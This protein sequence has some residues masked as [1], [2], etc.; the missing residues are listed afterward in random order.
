[1]TITEQTIY[2]AILILT[3]IAIGL[4]AVT[5]W[6]VRDTRPTVMTGVA[7]LICASLWILTEALQLLSPDARTALLWIKIEQV[8]IAPIPV[9]WV[10]LSMQVTGNESSLSTSRMIALSTIPFLSMVIL[11]LNESLG[12][13]MSVTSADSAMGSLVLQPGPAMVLFYIY[14]YSVIIGST[15]LLIQRMRFSPS[16]RWQGM[17]V[18]V[19]VCLCVIASIID[20]V[21]L[22]TVSMVKLTPL[23]LAISIP[24]YILT[25]ARTRR[26]DLVP[27]A[28]NNVL[29]II[30]DAVIVLDTEKRIIDMNPAAETLLGQ[31]LPKV[32]GKEINEAWQAWARQI[33]TLS[34]RPRGI[35][36]VRLSDGDQERV[37]D[38]RRSELKDWHGQLVSRVIVLRDITE[39]ALAE[40]ALQ[41]SEQHFRALTENATDLIATLKA[42]AL[43]TY[44]SPSIPKLLGFRV[45]EMVGRSVVDFAHPDDVAAIQAALQAATQNHFTSPAI[46]RIRN[47]DGSWRKLECALN[48]LLDHPAVHGI[49][50]NARDVTEREA[51]ASALRD[52]EERYSVHFANMSDVIYTYDPG[53]RIT[54]VSSGIERLLG[55][56]PEE[57]IG[58][59]LF[60]IGL[61]PLISKKHLEKALGEAKRLLSGESIESTLYEFIAKDGTVRIVEVSATPIF[62]DVRVTAVT[63]VARDITERVHAEEQLRDSLQEKEVLL[64]EVHHRV[65]NNLQIIASLLRLQS[66]N[67]D[68]PRTIAQ[69]QDSQNRIRSMALIHERLYRSTDLSTIDFGPYLRDLT[70]HLMQSYRDQANRIRLRVEVDKTQLD[71]DTAISCGLL[72]NELVSNALKH[73]FPEGR[74]GTIGV[75]MRSTEGNRHELVVWDDGVGMPEQKSKPNTLG[76]QLV[77]SLAR[78]LR[79]T[80]EFSAEGGTQIIVSF[81]GS[82]TIHS[83][84][85]EAVQ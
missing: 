70:G 76:L 78:Q 23:A 12:L 37:F 77:S 72:I 25:L 41:L 75:Q 52:S 35:H 51:V 5:R 7:L 20:L 33:D 1:M 18:L 63:N 62:Q 45:D 44:V 54:S 27:A 73:A 48:N 65:K 21:R 56:K 82:E 29:H 10:I 85:M 60:D 83:N 14:G 38:V 30:Q 4:Y 9:L 79:G 80:V 81:P 74:P 2:S 32:L 50:V 66:G 6:R 31:P 16:F 53:L 26:A 42:N 49:V 67:T 84:Q 22:D 69:F 15:Y 39:R 11:V 43:I 17:S 61:I 36:E 71:I 24:L 46:V 8:A 47:R 28:R 3:S 64:K 68:D 58:K 13:F 57:L 55:Y 19:G 34:R 59:T 40:E